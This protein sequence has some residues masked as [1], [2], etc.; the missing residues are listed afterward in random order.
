MAIKVTVRKKVITKGRYTLFLDFYP[1]ILNPTTGKLTRREY[2]GIYIK[3]NP[4]TPLEKNDNKLG[5]RNK[6]SQSCHNLSL[7]L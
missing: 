3:I 1:H 2:L 7:Y 4:K 6:M 5:K